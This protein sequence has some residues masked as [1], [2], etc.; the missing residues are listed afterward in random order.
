MYASQQVEMQPA[1]TLFEEPRH[2]YTAALLEALPE[3]SVDKKRLATIPGM[4]PG[5][6]DRPT[7]CV[8]NPRCNFATERCRTEPPAL[9]DFKGA[10]A[11]CLYPLEHGRPTGHPDPRYA[12]TE[13]EAMRPPSGETVSGAAS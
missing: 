8:F 3:R 5:I 11:R 10:K 12:G 6:A 1:A 2:P 13:A 4:V 9:V 7:G